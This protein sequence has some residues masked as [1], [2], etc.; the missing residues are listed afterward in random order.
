[1]ENKLKELNAINARKWPWIFKKNKKYNE[2]ECEKIKAD[3]ELRFK[4]SKI[5]YKQLDRWKSQ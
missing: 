2:A 4:R 3:L 5:K 1:M